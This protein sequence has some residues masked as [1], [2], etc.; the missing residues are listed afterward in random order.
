MLVVNPTLKFDVPGFLDLGLLLGKER[1]RCDLRSPAC[2][3][4]A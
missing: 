1:K 3:S 2:P 4:A